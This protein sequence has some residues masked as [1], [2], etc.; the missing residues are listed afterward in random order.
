MVLLADV[1]ASN[2]RV[3][4]GLPS[5]LVGVFAG[6]T[7]GIG[8]TAL[9][10]F[11]R[12]TTEPRIYFIGRSLEA[13][14]RLTDELNKL[15]SSGHYVFIQADTSLLVNVDKIC[16]D[17]QR[18]ESV[19]NLLFLSQGTLRF[20]GMLSTLTLETTAYL[21]LYEDT[22]EGLPIILSV[23]FY[24]RMRFIVNFLPQ[25]QRATSLRRVVTVQ[26]A[27]FEG[28]L[29]DDDFLCRKVPVSKARGHSSSM[30]T[31]AIETLAKK[32]PNVSFIHNFPGSINTNLIRGDE[33]IILQLVKYYFKIKLAF[34][35]MPFK[36]CGERHAFLCTNSKYPPSE[37][38]ASGSGVPLSAPVSV[39][40]GVDGK[41]GTGAYAVSHEGES[42]SPAIEKLLAQYRQE[43]KAEKLWQH[44][45]DQFTKITGSLGGPVTLHR[46]PTKYS[47]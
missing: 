27:G 10:E 26:S 40:R 45:E 41:V 1:Q 46:T 31:L 16:K 39:A 11:A 34:N 47:T 32:A 43:G 15:N 7:A 25:L 37:E 8:E 20:G 5:G 4:K 19:I 29:F 33:G 28:K 24:S 42:V 38:A 18:K 23:M 36:E 2:D 6:A 21:T 22:T 35:S 14:N 30:M 12:I 3:A 9:K 13:G 17:I 44:V